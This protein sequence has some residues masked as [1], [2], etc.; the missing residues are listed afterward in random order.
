[1]GFGIYQGFH[2]AEA[3]AFFEGAV[4][5]GHGAGGYQGGAAGFAG[6]GFGY[7]D[8]GEGWVA[9]HGIAGDAVGDSARVVVEEVGG[10]DLVVVVGGVGE[11]AAAV[12]VAHGVDAFYVGAEL[13]VYCDVAFVVGGDAGFVETQ[14]LG[15]GSA[16]YGEE[17]VGADGG[18]LLA[19]GAGYAYADAFG[20]RGESDAF[21]VEADVDAFALEDVE[22]GGGDVFV[23]V[24]DKALGALDDGDLGAEAAVH[25]AK[26]DAD[27]TAADDDEV[28]GEGVER[29][30]ACVGEE[31]DFVNAGEVGDGG[32]AAY[33]EEDLFGFE[34]VVAYADFVGS[35]E[36]GGAGVDGDFFVRAEGL[37]DTVAG[38]GDDGIAAGVDGFDIDG[39]GADCDAVLGG[40][41]DLA[42]S[43]GAGD[44]GLGGSA[45]GVDAGAAEEVALDEGYGLSGGGEA[46]GE[47]WAG[48]A[49]SDDDGVVCGH[50]RSWGWWLGW[51]LRLVEESIP[52]GL[53]PESVV[54]L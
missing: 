30:E 37:F 1:V 31:G 43:V 13:V 27:V 14:V 47:G 20:V 19:F 9:V 44:H 39:E 26:L 33:V 35:F 48:L 3:F 54:A 40:A 36:G 21:G 45:A 10:Y 51:R 28:F 34:D 11:G 16:A 52:Q 18:G 32:A 41:L 53:K 12:A 22:D 23:F 50:G 2:E 24:E 6:F 17:D 5:A 25:L 29:E 42:G 8:A 46:G 4:D 38:V 7:A 49:G 15:V